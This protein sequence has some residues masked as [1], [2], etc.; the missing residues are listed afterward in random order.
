MLDFLFSAAL[1][2]AAA[3][4]ATAGNDQ[5]PASVAEAPQPKAADQAP[6]VEARR[7]RPRMAGSETG[8]IDDA[9]IASKIR[10]RFDAAFDMNRPDRAE[11]FYAKCGCYR[12][13]PVSQGGD[14]N[15][16]GPGAEAANRLNYQELYVDLEYAPTNRFSLVAEVPF[17]SIQIKDPAG[18]LPVQTGISDFRAGVK[19]AL[20]ASER[21]YLTAQFRAYAPTGSAASGL[22][23]NHVSLEPSVIWYRRVGSRETVSAQ[24]G[25]WIPISSSAGVPITSSQKFGGQVLTYGVGASY[26]AIHRSETLRVSPVLEFVGWSVLN[27]FETN[28]SPT[29]THTIVNGKLGARF[30][31]GG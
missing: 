22:G 12:G 10:I 21:Q 6:A 16:P 18:M 20:L 3:N 14:P 19:V 31:F 11:F 5:R 29:A 15:A 28:G 25:G 13:V 4:H 7:R 27:G 30:T 9:V 23:T 2:A 24:F 17:R 1:L 26:D 8:Y